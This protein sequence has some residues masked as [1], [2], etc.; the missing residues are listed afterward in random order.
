M[1]D[2][3]ALVRCNGL[4]KGKLTAGNVLQPVEVKNITN[5]VHLMAL[6]GPLNFTAYVERP[7]MDAVHNGKAKFR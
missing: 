6:G 2:R 4:Y 1:L 7:A 3:L 5:L